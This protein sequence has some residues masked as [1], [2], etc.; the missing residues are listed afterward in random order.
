MADREITADVDMIVLA[1]GEC[2][3]I[4]AV[5]KKVDLRR[6]EDGK[7]WH[8]PNGHARHYR[9]SEVDRLK[10]ALVKE[11]ARRARAESR[12]DLRLANAR[13]LERRLSATQA[14]ITRMKR[15][16]IAGRCVVCGKSVSDQTDHIAE[17]HAGWGENGQ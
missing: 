5:P 4:F 7:T 15:R 8:C 17:R 10:A 2:G 3:A 1:C 12:A 11:S 14:V 13:R 16:I 6:R 9:D